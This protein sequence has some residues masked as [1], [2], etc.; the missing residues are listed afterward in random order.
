MPFWCKSC[1][2]R[3]RSGPRAAITDAVLVRELPLQMTFQPRSYHYRCRSDA[4]AAITDAVLARELPLQMPLCHYRCRSGA[5]AAITDAALARELPLQ[6]PL[7]PESCH[8]RCRSGA[9]AVI[10]DAAWYFPLG[11]IKIHFF[12]FGKTKKNTKQ[13]KTMVTPMTI[14]KKQK[15]KNNNK[16]KRAKHF[17][18][19]S[20]YFMVFHGI[21]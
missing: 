4:R 10:T 12:S 5:R 16:K 18:G 7:W 19:I 11:K 2:Y 1:H 6:M 20:W 3:C 17:L 9:R 15:N 8:F 14:K 13:N 21:S